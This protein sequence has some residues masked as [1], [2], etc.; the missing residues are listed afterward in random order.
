MLRRASFIKVNEL[1]SVIWALNKESH[2]IALK[3]CHIFPLYRFYLLVLQSYAKWAYL[4]LFLYFLGQVLSGEF[5]SQNSFYFPWPPH[6]VVP[7]II[8]DYIYVQNVSCMQCTSHSR[9]CGLNAK[10][11]SL[12]DPFDATGRVSYESPLWLH[13]VMASH[14]LGDARRSHVWQKVMRHFPLIQNTVGVF[15]IGCSFCVPNDVYVQNLLMFW[16]VAVNVAINEIWLACASGFWSEA[17]PE[18]VAMATNR[19]SV[20]LHFLSL[21]VYLP[22]SPSQLSW[23]SVFRKWEWGLLFV[24]HLRTPSHSHEV[25]TFFLPLDTINT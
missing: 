11:Q 7:L 23:S 24:C 21:S 20:V 8:T 3:V 12:S 9:A 22:L 5:S 15:I 6:W 13:L 17:A 16:C 14:R 4:K 18:P 1:S 2:V 19:L 25:I 10:M